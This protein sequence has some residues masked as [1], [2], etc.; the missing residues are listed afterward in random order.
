VNPLARI[1]YSIAG[2]LA[3]AASALAP[4]GGGKAARSFR[5]RRGILERFSEWGAKHRDAA[6]PLLWVHAPSVGE[7]LQALPVLTELR[8]RH[9]EL[10]LAY[11]FF[12]PSAER[13]ASLVGADFHDY[14]PFDTSGA[15]RTAIQAL[16]PNAI[17]FSK[18]DVW[19]LLVEQARQS[20]VR[21]GMLSATIP[22]SSMRR[23]RVARLALG[24][25][26][27]YLDA[28]GAISDGDAIRLIEAGVHPDRVIV[29][30]DTRYDQAWQKAQ[31][32][33]DARDALLAPLTSTRFTLVAG[34]TWPSDEE[35]LFPAWVEVKKRHGDVRMII[36]PHELPEE[37]LAS[38]EAWA[39]SNGLKSARFADAAGA[40]ADV[41]IVDR[42]GILGDLYAL[43]DAA[44]VGGGFRSAGLHSLLE[45]AAF[46][47]PVI[48][49]PRHED[50]RDAQL[51]VAAGGAFRCPDA[52][53][54]ESRVTRWVESAE[55][56]ERARNAARDVVYKGLGA[57]E[58]SVEIV[59]RLI[60]PT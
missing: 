52:S 41:V 28:V 50:N 38:I 27:S 31:S 1:P 43:A 17:V 55:S 51:L 57:A 24:E 19:P 11:T 26:Y 45:P 46:G 42:Y 8:E 34:S 60:Y 30:G 40:D 32:R 20:K 58:R 10:Q 59:E 13:F 7:G 44:Y 35:R 56:L 6:R 53:A 54:I 39:Q 47:A 29:T 15:A 12:S 49:G 21:L 37:R 4:G 3:N 48:I 23:S 16:R 33:T 18:L 9:P 5:G 14:L 25:A 2:A 22:A 36:A